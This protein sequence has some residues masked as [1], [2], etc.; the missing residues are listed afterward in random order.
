MYPDRFAAAGSV[1]Y[2][3]G[4]HNIKVGIQDTW[5]RY[6]QFR[7][8][9]GDLRAQFQNGVPYQVTILNTPLNF[10]DNLKADLGIYAQD[11]WTI[12][13]LTLNYGARW[14]YFASGVP[15]ETSGTGRFIANPRTFG[16]IDMPTWKSIAPRGG[17]VYDLFG[18]QKTAVKFSLGKFMQAGTTG[19]SN[20]YNPL[21]LLTTTVAWT[22]LNNDGVPQG[23]LGCVYQTAGCEINVS[24]NATTKGQ[25]SPSFGVANLPTFD[26]DIER[27]YNVETSVSVQHELMSNVSVTAGWYHRSY[28]NIWR[29]TNTG[30]NF[31]DF[32]PF[33]VYSPI[34]GSP[35]TYY[36][37]S[38]TKASAMTQ[39]LVDESAPDRSDVYNGF[40]YNFS[41]RLTHGITIFGGGMSER[42]L[43][44]S[45]DDDW[46]PNL[47]LYCDQSQTGVPFRTQ[48]KIAGTVPMPYGFQVGLSFQSLPGY[49]FGTSSVGALTG[50]SGPS[51]APSA[52]QLANPSGLGTVWLVTRTTRY[53]ADMPCVAQG[54]CAAGAL[55]DPGITQASLSIPLVAPMTEYGDRIN[56]LDLNIAKNFKLNRFN[57][58]PKIDFFNLLNAAPVYSVRSLN[59]GTAS[60]LQPSSVLNGRT[61]QLGAVVR[62]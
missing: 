45:C 23:Q 28:H 51:G 56:Q 1:S 34:D 33:T 43:S 39:N 52:T 8:A 35:I 3:T 12:N 6:R 22:D 24:G 53:T 5:G 15:E 14:E 42:I 48:F 36:N 13:R 38:A 31:G 2:V 41:A 26:P 7:S 21:G 44:N 40:E 59:Y 54:T 49:L 19:F 20:R 37:I 30:I 57:I 16:P 10:Q 62:F 29:R 18:N 11:S 61:F 55:V 58:Q 17:I 32:T 27:M 9:N 25:L 60:Y 50:V 46:N 47:L 4:T